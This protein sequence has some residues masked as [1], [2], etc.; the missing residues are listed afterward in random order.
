MVSRPG[1]FGRVWQRVA[2][3]EAARIRDAFV[4]NAEV[5]AGARSGLAFFLAGLTIVIYLM[6]LLV[7]LWLGLKVLGFSGG[8]N[9]VARFLYFFIVV[10]G[11]GFCWLARPRFPLTSGQVVSAQEAPTL[12]ALV[13]QVAEQLNVP[14]PTRLT[15]T[16]DVNAFMGRSGFPPQPA[17]GF[18]LP[19]WYGL[20]PQERVAVIAHE[21]AHLRNGDPT[22]TGLIGIA[23]NMLGHAVILL[24]P[25]ALMR[26]RAGLMGMLVNGVMQLLSMIPLGLYSSIVTWSVQSSSGRS[27]VPTC[28]PPRLLGLKLQCPPWIKCT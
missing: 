6:L 4:E 28:Y 9:P 27:F 16:E 25:D 15:L 1:L 3:R 8:M 11:L 23:L 10:L 12:F 26:A 22:R 17:L 20:H 19:L 21:L 14:V 18:G 24:A 2:D 7:A 13:E 5:P